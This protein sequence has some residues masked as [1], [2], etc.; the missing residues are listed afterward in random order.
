MPDPASAA[1][2]ANST[3]VDLTVD[4]DGDFDADAETGE[5]QRKRAKLEPQAAALVPVVPA[6]EGKAAAN[7][8]AALLEVGRQLLAAFPHKGEQWNEAI[9]SDGYNWNANGAPRVSARGFVKAPTVCAASGCNTRKLM[10]LSR[11]GWLVE[12]LTNVHT[13][14]KPQ[15][16]RA[17]LIVIDGSAKA[18]AI[19]KFTHGQSAQQVLESQMVRAM[20]SADPDAA[21]ARV[22]KPQQLKHLRDTVKRALMS[23]T[24][25]V[26]VVREYGPGG[27]DCIIH[28]EFIST[29]AR[30]DL[31][32]STFNPCFVIITKDLLRRLHDDPRCVVYVDGTF[33]I[34]ANGLQVC[35]LSINHHGYGIA[36]AFLV[37]SGR[38]T[39]TYA[40]MLSALLR[41]TGNVWQPRAVVSDFEL[42]L[43]NA[44]LNLFPN[45]QVWACYFHYCQAVRKYCIE[46]AAAIA[47]KP[48]DVEAQC[49]RVFLA[50][51]V[52][53]HND[54]WSKLRSLA[55]A[56]FAQYFQ[57]TFLEYVYC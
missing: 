6:A 26:A 30:D 39:E 3:V 11:E 38:D 22:P 12:S 15:Q 37:S 19:A 13:C 34:V 49:K 20:Q 52:V 21:L 46:H 23:E 18:E 1:A 27:K 45:T 7:A 50:P 29:S 10:R 57:R 16:Q 8:S 24:D 33:D 28:M 4:S 43:Q 31:P 35:T 44:C 51:T 32:V 53:L 54:E 9:R 2:G 48:S 14:E 55:G 17:P 47:A 25:L 56:Q 5:P 36:C 42:A 41:A 40:S